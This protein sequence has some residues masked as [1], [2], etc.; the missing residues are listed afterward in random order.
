MIWHLFNQIDNSPEVQWRLIRTFQ[1]S[2]MH[3]IIVNFSPI[4]RFIFN[5]AVLWNF[6]LIYWGYHTT[7]SSWTSVNRV[8]RFKS[9]SIIKTTKGVKLP[10]RWLN[11]IG[12]L[13]SLKPVCWQQV[14]LY[15][16]ITELLLQNISWSYHDPIISF[17]T[18]SYLRLC[19]RC[20]F[21]WLIIKKLL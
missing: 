3:E 7:I 12:A 1:P 6:K 10:I 15:Q 17:S 16:I 8:K 9:S 18:V 14:T 4:S 21:T 11:D 20:T 19:T 2:I 13:V 5:C